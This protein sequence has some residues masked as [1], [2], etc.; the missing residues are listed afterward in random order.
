MRTAVVTV[1]L[2][3]GD[4]GK[5]ATVDALCRHLGADLVV[6]YSGGSQAGH[7]VTLPDGRRHV[8]SQFGAGT[9]AG[10]PTYLGSQMILNPTALEREAA[11]LTELGV[12]D[13]FGTLTVHP[14]AL[15]STFFH[16]TLN[17]ARELSRGSARHGSCGHGIGETRDGWLRHGSDAVVAGDLARPESLLP[18]LELLRQRTILE[19]QPLVS[20]IPEADRDQADLLGVSAGAVAERLLEVEAKLR[21]SPEPPRC[22]VAVFEGAQGVLLDEWRGFHPH[23]TWST[24]TPHFA[25]EIARQAGAGRVITLG[26]T[27]A[28]TSRHGA[29]PLPTFEPELT[30]GHLDL[31]NLWNPWQGSIRVGWL[32]LV[33][34]RYAA[35]A[36]GPLDGLAVSWLDE[37][38]RGNVCEA[39]E[40][41]FTPTVSPV[42]DLA[43]QE[44]YNARLA[45]ARPVLTEWSRG[46]L[47]DALGRIAPVVVEAHGPTHADREVRLGLPAR[48][49]TA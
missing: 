34:L 4:E 2:G 49:G 25:R 32:D 31:T 35:E 38:E 47:L 28:F 8:F 14:S 16:Q 27:R 21:F 17:R 45:A 36:A 24:V 29:G 48:A 26:I 46:E 30:A 15:V 7:G 3:F 13:P 40:D 39:Y 10:V 44:S 22:D 12:S 6:R 20:K 1:G 42:P 18:K 33:L 23:T 43:R 41:G 37:F 5:G 19:L 9:L 11:H